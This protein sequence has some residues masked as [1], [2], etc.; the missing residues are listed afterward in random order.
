MHVIRRAALVVAFLFTSF[1]LIAGVASATPDYGH[2]SGDGQPGRVVARAA[3]SHACADGGPRLVLRNDASEPD[4]KRRSGPPG[5]FG[6]CVT[7]AAYDGH[8]VGTWFNNKSGTF[9]TVG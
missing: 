6:V 4:A 8:P 9:G 5:T 1:G 3:H 7:Q 2:V